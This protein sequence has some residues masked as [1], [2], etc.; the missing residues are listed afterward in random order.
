MSG[1]FNPTKELKKFDI[2]EIKTNPSNFVTETSIAN[3]VAFLKLANYFYYKSGNPIISD[4][5][6]DKIEEG[7]KK[8]APKNKYWSEIREGVN[9]DGSE[10]KAKE[11]VK[12]PYWM[13]SMDKIK[14]G[15]EQVEKWSTKYPGFYV[16][17]EKLDG[18]SCLLVFTKDVGVK[19][20]S[21]GDG[22]IGQDVSSLLKH[23]KIK[24]PSNIEKELAIRGELII[25][26]SK[27]DEKYKETKTDPRSMV[28]GLMN[29]KYADP[30]ELKD[31]EIVMYEII[32]PSGIKPSQQFEKIS[33]MGFHTPRNEVLK[34]KTLDEETMMTMLSEWKKES[35]YDIDGL[36]VTQDKAQERN[37]SG[38][39]D[40][41]RAF[42][43]D[44]DEQR[45]VGEV[46]EIL[47]EISRHGKI[48]PRIKMKPLKIGLITIQKATAF[49]AKF[50]KDNKL[51]PGA[52]VNIIRSGD[53][54]PYIESVVKEAPLGAEMPKD[55]KYKWHSGGYDIYIDEE[56]VSE[57]I[58]IKK[59]LYFMTSL[60]AEGISSSTVKRYFDAGFTTIHAIL[61]I[62][63]EELLELPNTK[64]RLATKQ[65]AVLHKV[66]DTEHPLEKLM[67]ASGV[68]GLGMGEKKSSLLIDVYPDIMTKNITKSDI[69]KV[70]G[71]EEKTAD[72]FLKGLPKFKK[73]LE[74]TG[75][76][77]VKPGS[78]YSKEGKLN[79]QIIVM[80]GFRDKDLKGEIEALGGEV[81]DTLTSK[82]TILLAKD[83]SE[84]SSKIDKARKL[85]IPIMDVDGFKKKYF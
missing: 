15:K 80:T 48:I 77:Y 41:S 5:V 14:P 72:V 78:V 45:G 18:M 29:S 74:E 60:E 3:G 58:E 4:S 6:Y 51:G 31:L 46:E 57:S 71:F 8:R 27:F 42:K 79:G 25:S 85:K 12:L 30:E 40:Y 34:K 73:W 64:E 82:T 39:P 20:Y 13:G 28:A 11:K 16:I 43:M 33:E 10:E 21:R 49:N 7:L 62:T 19:L 26:R 37:T 84:E 52:V 22:S 61:N 53:V 50:I 54:I 65:L 24:T 17:S 68:F 75:V 67:A 1:K 2:E 9:E 56:N 63:E 55:I 35:K 66:R 47:W 36:I 32:E 76:K 70:D 23:I 44:L 81:A 59:I 83:T 69:I 38:N